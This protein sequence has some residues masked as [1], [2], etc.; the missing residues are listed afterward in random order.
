MPV[1]V[2]FCGRSNKKMIWVYACWRIAA[3]A[4]KHPGGN[5]SLVQEIRQTVGALASSINLD[6]RITFCIGI[7]PA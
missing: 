5:F 2:I 7:Q 4:N 6:A 1:S 3:V